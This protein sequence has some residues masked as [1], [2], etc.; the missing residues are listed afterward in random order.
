M[1][2]YAEI[3]SPLVM[4]WVSNLMF[5]PRIESAAVDLGFEIKLIERPEDLMG[6]VA[7]G[8][9]NAF[10]DRITYE[11]PALIIC[12][13]EANEI[14]WEEWINWL[15]TASSTRR[16][17]VICFGSHKDVETLK[18]AKSA[19]A[20][21]VLARSRFFSSLPEMIQKYARRIDQQALNMDCQQ[22][23]DSRAH[24]GIEQFNCGEYF[25][26]HESLEA[27]WMEDSSV[28]RI[29]YRAI[30]QVAVAYYQIQ[31]ENYPGAVKMFLRLRGW[32]N[33]LPDVCKS[34]DVA[35][36]RHDAFEVYERI[37][38]LG[39]ERLNEFDPLSFRPI[40][41]ANRIEK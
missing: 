37:L 40:A 8:S 10:M 16:I 36:L 23:L 34:V 41:F 17:P 5:S 13:L 22:N 39:P 6:D 15:R 14:P 27:A 38:A 21:A 1:K 30:L 28:G 26:A 11:A 31:Q 7:S 33:S 35:K 18:R 2:N 9:R 3:Y 20:D 4:A 24:Q 32:I 25:E 12:D 29:L 19:G